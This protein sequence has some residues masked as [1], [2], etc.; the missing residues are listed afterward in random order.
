MTALYLNFEVAAVL[1]HQIQSRCAW[2][3]T[4]GLISSESVELSSR[5]RLARPAKRETGRWAGSRQDG[6]SDGRCGRLERPRLRLRSGGDD[7]A[8]RNVEA[9]GEVGD[10]RLP[11]ARPAHDARS[12]LFHFQFSRYARAAL[13]TATPATRTRSG[14][15]GARRI[16]W[17]PGREVT[18]S[19]RK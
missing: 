7:S 17:S 8:N 19:C 4:W 13:G 12:P 3:E 5:S 6:L 9:G 15:A 10:G 11:H 16:L 2:F 14:E 18:G 1:R